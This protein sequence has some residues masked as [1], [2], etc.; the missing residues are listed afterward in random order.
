MSVRNNQSRLEFLEMLK[1]RIDYY[2]LSELYDRVEIQI[3]SSDQI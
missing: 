1:D 3:S 2:K